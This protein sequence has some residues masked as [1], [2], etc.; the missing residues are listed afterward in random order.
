MSIR[1]PTRIP[2]IQKI[3]L[4]VLW[5]R[6]GCRQ[7]IGFK[8]SGFWVQRFKTVDQWLCRKIHINGPLWEYFD[9]VNPEP[10]YET[11]PV[12]LP[13]R[14]AYS[15]ERTVKRLNVE[16]R[17]SNIERRILMTLRF[18]YFKTSESR[19]QRDLKTAEY[20]TAA[21]DE[22]TSAGSRLELVESS[23]IEFRRVDSLYLVFFLNWQNSLFDVG[24]SMFDV[25]FLVNPY[26]T[27]VYF[28][29]RLAAFQASG[30]AEPRT[31]YPEPMNG[32]SWKYF[33]YIP[34][35]APS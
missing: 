34:T 19:W 6:E 23:R 33:L 13:A 12:R 27:S 22:L 30:W 10:S 17:T 11:P 1:W 32:L 35:P 28:L 31:F 15:S 21:C 29:I 5:T 18:I 20:W 4:R 7:A 16:H 25:H 24:R 2:S 8:G 9:R 14:R 3:S 26:E